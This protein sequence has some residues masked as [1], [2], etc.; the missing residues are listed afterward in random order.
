MIDLQIVLI[1]IIAL[2]TINL[3]YI[4]FLVARVLKKAMSVLD[5]AL[6][7]VNNIDAS[8][9]NGLEKAK[10]LEQPLHAIAET[11]KVVSGI[12]NGPIAKKAANSILGVLQGKNASEKREKDIF[13]SDSHDRA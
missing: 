7:A 2:L 6:E 5:R 1:V 12:V 13:A 11:T 8:V 3:I 10:E 4:G 9:Q